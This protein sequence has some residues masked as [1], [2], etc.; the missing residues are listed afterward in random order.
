MGLVV[1][2]K[3]G[4]GF[5][6]VCPEVTVAVRA[7]APCPGIVRLAHQ[8]EDGPELVL[9]C[10]FCP[11]CVADHRLPPSGV[12]PDPDKF[13]NAYSALYRPMCP[14][15]FEEWQRSSGQRVVAPP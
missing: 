12:V 15:C 10:W 5:M 2:P 6:F 13:L 3:H 1:C 4:N 8:A 11:A 9:A 14:K 7:S